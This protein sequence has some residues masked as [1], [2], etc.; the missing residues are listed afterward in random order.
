M[1]WCL[2][3]EWQYLC[4]VCPGVGE[5]LRPIE[6]ALRK[7]FIPAVLGHKGMI[8]SDDAR[9]LYANGVKQGGGSPSESPTSRWGRCT[10]YRGRQW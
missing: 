4:R 3:A 10:R 1:V 8:V 7:D 5:H 9:K 2:Q 6:E